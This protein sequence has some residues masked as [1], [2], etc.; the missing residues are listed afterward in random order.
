VYTTGDMII[1]DG[2]PNRIL[3]ASVSFKIVY[4]NSCTI[5]AVD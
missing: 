1:S 2:S 4:F 3:S 5:L